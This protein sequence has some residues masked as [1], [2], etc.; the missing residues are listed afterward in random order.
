MKLV[1]SLFPVCAFFVASVSLDLPSGQL[2]HQS[3]ELVAR[4]NTASTSADRAGKE[5]WRSPL[6]E[7]GVP[8]LAKLAMLAK[9]TT[10]EESPNR[11]EDVHQGTNASD[12]PVVYTSEQLARYRERYHAAQ[13]DSDHFRNLVERA[14]AAGLKVSQDE[15]NELSRLSAVTEQQ[16][17]VFTR[18]SLGQPVDR[19]DAAS[20]LQD[21]E[22][23]E[24]AKSGVYSAQQ[25]VEYKQFYLDAMLRLRS[26]KN[27]LTEIAKVREITKAE[28]KALA[29]LQRTYNLQGRRWARVRAG[30]PT[31]YGAKKS[32]EDLLESPKLQ[33]IARSSGYSVKEL[34]EA[35]RRFLDANNAVRA[36]KLRLTEIEEVRQ[37]TPDEKTKLQTL[38]KDREQQRLIN[39]RMRQ[40]RA[41]TSDLAL[42]KKDLT[43]LL[44]D[45]EMQRIAQW[46]GYRVEE[47]A[48]Q[49]R[50][51]LDALYA[52]RA[53][54]T[55]I[56]AVKTT[57]GTLTTDEEDHY[58]KID[59]AYQ[60]QRTAWDRMTQ[61][62][63]AIPPATPLGGLSEKVAGLRA[64]GEAADVDNVAHSFV[65]YT[66]RQ[67][68]V[69]DQRYLDVLD[70]LHAF[71]EAMS[72]AAQSG[73]PI[74]PTEDEQLKGLQRVAEQRRTEWARVR[75]GLSV[76]RVAA[77][78]DDDGG[79]SVRYTARQI[80]DYHRRYLDALRT[81]RTAESQIQA[82]REAGHSPT[83]L[84]DVRLRVLRDDF[85]R[86][87][88]MWIRARSGKPVDR[89]VYTRRADPGRMSPSTSEG[90]SASARAPANSPGSQVQEQAA[91]QAKEDASTDQ[92]HGA[93]QPLQ[94]SG[95]RR[96][97][98]PILSSASRWLQS[99]G[100]QWHALP[101]TR[102]YVAYPRLNRMVK[103][104]EVLRAEPA[105]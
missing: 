19:S 27:Q 31:Q 87:R 86:K 9:R 37:V 63:S 30:K 49:K 101:W 3:R 46:G 98:A 44:K 14:K 21:P 23:Q 18:A 80:E 99:L 61:G 82:A 42:P 76:D 75:Q 50:A 13:S 81:V 12:G 51:Y 96:L 67:I 93:H 2:E 34:A 68:A 22:I 40:G 103:P 100:R 54:M 66:L 79:R 24:L 56:A 77:A 36:F 70:H 38:L 59:R 95:P 28:E 47:V 35:R 90:A 1:H 62:T 71:Q 32:I 57:G 104:A 8:K 92:A 74:T 33:A 45:A 97:I 25:L 78:A 69:Y 58:V 29:E 72:L 73:R 53:A 84:D 65:A 105:L 64:N 17:L 91:R 11:Q 39:A 48:V 88:V 83:A 94:I 52:Y 85:N 41:A 15:V 43:L 89:L 102:G 5:P 7:P 10:D 6:V 26:R 60:L 20:L 16:R 4:S 55:S